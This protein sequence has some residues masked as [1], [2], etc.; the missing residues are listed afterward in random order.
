M[1]GDNSDK[2]TE[3][4]LRGSAI[5]TVLLQVQLD[6]KRNEADAYRRLAR[7]LARELDLVEKGCGDLASIRPVLEQA[8]AVG[9]LPGAE[10]DKAST[11][12]A[13][14]I[15]LLRMDRSRL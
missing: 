14:E 5:R 3:A 4:L 6:N 1:S 9:L 7:R 10:A 15:D 2:D 12:A 8:R 13:P 11:E